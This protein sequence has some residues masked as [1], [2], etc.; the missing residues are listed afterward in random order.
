MATRLA[1]IGR[2]YKDG[3][4]LAYL[5]E[6]GYVAASADLPIAGLK[7][8]KFV[9][10]DE[11]V[12]IFRSETGGEIALGEG[13]AVL[14]GSIIEADEGGRVSIGKGS[15][16][17]PGCM[18]IAAIADIRI[19]EGVLLAANC[20]LYPHNHGTAPNLPIIKQPCYAKGPIVVDDNAWLGTGVVVLSGVTIGK[21]AVIGAGSVVTKSIPPNAIAVGNPARVVSTR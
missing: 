14:R 1:S 10:I 9:F 21:G 11:W 20:A 12:T 8:G 17:H 4:R 19:G 15:W 6:K 2:S 18:L 7:L 16:V 13:C 5:T 3:A